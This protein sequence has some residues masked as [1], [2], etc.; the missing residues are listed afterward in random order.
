MLNEIGFTLQSHLS[1]NELG[2]A[3]DYLAQSLSSARSV[4]YQIGEATA[5]RGLGYL[6]MRQ[7]RYQDAV[8]QFNNSLVIF[9]RLNHP[10]QIAHALNNIG[11]A[12]FFMENYNQSASAFRES[13]HLSTL[14]NDRYVSGRAH[15]FL[16]LIAFR[17]SLF[18]NAFAHHQI[19]LDT[20]QAIQRDLMVIY[21]LNALG[22][23][24]LGLGNNDQAESFLIRALRRLKQISASPEKN[25]IQI[26]TLAGLA[27]VLA[28]LQD[29]DPALELL[30]LC[31]NHQAMQQSAFRPNIEALVM[32]L[33]NILTPE[34]VAE[35]V[36]F[37]RT[38]KLDEA[39]EM[40]LE[41]Y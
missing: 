9:R 15:Y 14:T 4:R 32:Q 29:Y 41:A 11:Q 30:G 36:G 38:L 27:S 18:E 24:A 40:L 33:E 19:A 17:E 20:A 12:L 37:G 25:I 34:K 1:P 13:M 39:V 5:L 10:Q 23:C 35:G 3:H 2:I 26:E 22:F 16:G 21:C 28:S 7:N 31:I 8:E 6:L